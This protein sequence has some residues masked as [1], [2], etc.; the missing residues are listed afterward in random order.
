MKFIALIFLGPCVWAGKPVVSTEEENKPNVTSS[1]ITGNWNPDR[2]EAW[3]D[4]ELVGGGQ[5]C[6]AL[7]HYPCA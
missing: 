5:V 1:N 4:L 2:T 3:G 6:D 7:M